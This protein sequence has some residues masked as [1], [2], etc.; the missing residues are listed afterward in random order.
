MRFLLLSFALL[1]AASQSKA[2]DGENASPVE[3]DGEK[4]SFV[5]VKCLE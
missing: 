1:V 3:T 4:V 2:E 5:P